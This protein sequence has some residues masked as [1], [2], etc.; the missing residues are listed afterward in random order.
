MSTS[1]FLTSPTR[2]H[3]IWHVAPV[4]S[5][6]N[7][8]AAETYD[9]DHGQHLEL[10]QSSNV[11][12][13]GFGESSPD[14]VLSC[15]KKSGKQLWCRVDRTRVKNGGYN[16]VKTNLQQNW[17]AHPVHDY[18]ILDGEVFSQFPLW[19]WI[20]VVFLDIVSVCISWTQGTWITIPV[21]LYFFVKQ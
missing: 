17:G 15:L 11:R 18:D 7:R 20:A 10:Q 5:M 19:C 13:P 6:T 4:P 16:D 3:S 1:C 14:S 2:L 8:Q 12:R 21:R 9:L